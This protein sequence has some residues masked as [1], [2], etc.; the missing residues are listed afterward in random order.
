ML[1]I[2]SLHWTPFRF[3]GKLA[4]FWPS[5]ASKRKFQDACV[6][7]DS[8]R[9]ELERVRDGPRK[10]RCKSSKTSLAADINS[11]KRHSGPRHHALQQEVVQEA[12]PPG[13]ESDGDAD[14]TAA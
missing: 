6:E 1:L 10:A 5:M 12:R 13:R 14:V 4:H 8:L 11:L 9:D 7:Q 2:L 3:V